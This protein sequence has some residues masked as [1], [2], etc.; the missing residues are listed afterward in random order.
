MIQCKVISNKIALLKRARSFVP[1]ETL[2]EMY[3]ALV[4]PHFNYYS[5]IWNDGSCSITDKLSSLHVCM[6]IKYIIVL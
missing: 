1:R 2:I 6:A 3:N 5:T 4:W